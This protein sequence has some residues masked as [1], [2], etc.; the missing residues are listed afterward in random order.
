[1]VLVVVAVCVFVGLWFFSRTGELFCLSVRG[2]KVLVLR[3]RAPGNFVSEARAIIARAGIRSATI[4]AIK[5]EDRARLVFSG[6]IDEGTEQR[7]RNMFALYPA[8][9]L[10]KAPLIAKPTLGQVVGVAWLAWLLDRSRGA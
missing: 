2:G 9:Q 5:G 1:M 6:K 4:R 10:R 7:L 3:G 8:A